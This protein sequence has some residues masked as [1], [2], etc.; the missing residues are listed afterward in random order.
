MHFFLSS[1]TDYVCFMYKDSL[2]RVHWYVNIYSQMLNSFLVFIAVRS[3]EGVW[4]RSLL[5]WNP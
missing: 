4:F 3:A 5:F 2:A 1:S